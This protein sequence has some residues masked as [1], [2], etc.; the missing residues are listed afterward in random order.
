MNSYVDIQKLSHLFKISEQDVRK[1]QK[2]LNIK[3]TAYCCKRTI[4]PYVPDVERYEY[5]KPINFLFELY[6]KVDK[7]DYMTHLLNLMT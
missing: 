1:H 7:N 4:E 3:S 2:Y 5:S 6:S